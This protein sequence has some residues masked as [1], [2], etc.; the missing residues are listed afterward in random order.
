MDNDFK[1]IKEERVFETGYVHIPGKFIFIDITFFM[2]LLNPCLDAVGNKLKKSKVDNLLASKE[3]HEHYLCKSKG[4]R[5]LSESNYVEHEHEMK[6]AMS[7]AD[8]GY[9]ILF[10]PKGMFQRQQKKFDIF[11]IKDHIIL[12]ADL[13]CISSKNPDTIANRIKGGSEQASRVVIEIASNIEKKELIS[14]LR[15]GIYK[16][17][18]LKEVFLFYNGYFYVLPKELI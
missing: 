4:T 7:L 5:V 15:S 17:S 11:I 2:S 10:T 18:L 6:T 14:G 1:P 12:K 8:K 13:K 16:N 9:N 3:W